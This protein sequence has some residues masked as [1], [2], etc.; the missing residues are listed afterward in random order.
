[1]PCEARP[2]PSG[3]VGSLDEVALAIAEARNIAGAF[4]RLGRQAHPTFA[5]RCA[6]V[7][8]ALRDALDREFPEL[9]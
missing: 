1:M 8:V 3:P 9:L 5:W 2:S 4:I 7:G 6:K